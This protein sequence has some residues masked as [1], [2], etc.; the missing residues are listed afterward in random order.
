MLFR[1]I[2]KMLNNISR[3]IYMMIKLGKAALKT[4]R[5]GKRCKFS[6]TT[7][8]A[9]MVIANGPSSKKVNY[10]LYVG[11]MDFLCMN[12][13][14]YNEDLFFKIKPKYYAMMD[15][16]SFDFREESPYVENNK[17][18]VEIFKRVN[19]PMTIVTLQKNVLPIDNAN[20]DYAYL[21]ISAIYSDYCQKIILKMY[22][23]NLISIGYSSTAVAGVYYMIMNKYNT[24]YL[25][26]I[27]FNILDRYY[28]DR[29]NNIYLRDIHNYGS[30]ERNITEEGVAKGEFYKLIEGYAKALYEFKLLNSLA[31]KKKINIYNLAM[32]SFVDS[33][34]KN[35]TIILE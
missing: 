23:R 12:F 2:K 35:D 15:M 3:T 24:I 11:K 33:F 34:E 26:G 28:I 31:E 25:T 32:E 5:N 6:K 13:F 4:I 27:D 16:N 10:E 14:C 22:E 1:R 30:E 20:I 19:W 8:K 7:K 18:L 9:A 29:N 17:K 21:P